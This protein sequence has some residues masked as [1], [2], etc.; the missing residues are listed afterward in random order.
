MR[1]GAK[2]SAAVRG[3]ARSEVECRLFVVR[4]GTKWSA[5]KRER[6]S[7]SLRGLLRAVKMEIVRSAARSEVECRETVRSAARSEVECRLFVVRH[8]TKWSA[9]KRRRCVACYE[10]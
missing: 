10:R 1:H 7:A 4:H 6:H 2:W 3:A 9:A 5:A 8:G